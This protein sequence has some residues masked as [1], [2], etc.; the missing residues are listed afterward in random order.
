MKTIYSG[1]RLTVRVP[2]TRREWLCF[3]FGLAAI[4]QMIAGHMDLAMDM[5]QFSLLFEILSRLPEESP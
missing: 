5:L 4:Y 2:S 1:K 3:L